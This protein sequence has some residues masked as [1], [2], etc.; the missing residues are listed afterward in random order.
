[1]KNILLLF[2]LVL[3]TATFAQEEWGDMKGNT[4]TMVEIAP[5]WPGCTGSKAALKSCFNSNL[6]Q[7][8]STNFKYP[9]EEY[10]NNIQ[11]KVIVDFVIN[12]EGLPEIQSITGGNKGLQ[13]EA[14]RNIML[15]PQMK[16]GMLG[17][18]PRAIKYKVPFNFKT[19]K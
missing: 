16:P 17:G 10:K 6:S 18:K 5:V 7:H 1:M 2:A 13:E 19:G 4:L 14:R 15:I 9:A 12:E 8:I 3:S 11:G